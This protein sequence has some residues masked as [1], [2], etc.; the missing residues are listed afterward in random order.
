VKSQ[1]GWHIIQVLGHTDVPLS[2]SQIQQKR[3]TAFSEWLAKA[4]DGATII[5]SET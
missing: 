4:K 3:D 2:A 1:F 5:N